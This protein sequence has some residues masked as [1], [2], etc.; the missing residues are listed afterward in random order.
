[1]E[2][3][4]LIQWTPLTVVFDPFINANKFDGPL[5]LHSIIDLSN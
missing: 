4:I 5:T 2:E 3:I 1:M